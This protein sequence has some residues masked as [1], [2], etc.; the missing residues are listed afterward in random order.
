[1]NKD[2]KIEDIAQDVTKITEEELIKRLKEKEV[3]LEKIPFLEFGYYAEADFRAAERK[4]IKW[5]LDGGE[6][7]REQLLKLY[8]NI[9]D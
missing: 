6:S 5:A 2:A 9:N 8:G 7:N 1:M 4:F 3:K